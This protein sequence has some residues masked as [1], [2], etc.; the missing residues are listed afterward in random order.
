M[1]SQMPK[2]AYNVFFLMKSKIII[3]KNQY[4]TR[5]QVLTAGTEAALVEV[6]LQQIWEGKQGC[7]EGGVLL[8]IFICI[9]LFGRIF[10]M[11]KAILC[12]YCESI[13]YSVHKVPSG[14][15][16]KQHNAH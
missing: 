12:S 3:K 4:G 16:C 15:A 10:E 9:S 2:V 7:R 5:T 8:G 11:E 13:C 1:P 14:F 6:P